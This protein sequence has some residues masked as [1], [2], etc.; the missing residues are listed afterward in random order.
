MEK[1]TTST[2]SVADYFKEKL[3]KQAGA[4]RPSSPLATAAFEDEDE[5][6]RFGIGARTLAGA[7][8]GR[9]VEGMSA[10]AGLGPR[11]GI[12]ATSMKTSGFV[13]S[14]RPQESVIA[15]VPEVA[16]VQTQEVVIDDMPE[17]KRKKSKRSREETAEGEGEGDAVEAPVAPPDVDPAAKSKEKKKKKKRDRGGEE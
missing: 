11:F 7:D 16:V 6:P 4:S 1:L 9:S 17:K 10:T 13:M 12:G 15:E 8:S 3:A 2:K 14:S 5:R